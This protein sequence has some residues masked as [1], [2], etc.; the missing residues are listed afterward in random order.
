MIEPETSRVTLR[1]DDMLEANLK[2][3]MDLSAGKISLMEAAAKLGDHDAGQTLHRMAD[4]GL[5]MP[6]LPDEMVKQQAAAS[7]DALRSAM[8]QPAAKPN[9]ESED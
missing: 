3:L 4:A 5:T 6:R 7:L 2:I 8:R 1:S 9:T